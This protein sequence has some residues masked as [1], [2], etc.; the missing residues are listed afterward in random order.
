MAWDV[1]YTNEFGDWFG[2][3]DDEVR[4]DV[5]AAVEMLE[6]DGPVLGRPFVDTLQGSRIANLKEL[7]P[8]GGNIRILFAFDPRR[9]AILLVGGDKTGR[10]REWYREMIPIAER[11]YEEYLE[12]LR[13]EGILP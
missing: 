11:L 8:R 6:A 13:R 12:E 9:S 10:W 5:I 2:E 4:E 3:L 7:R 1:E